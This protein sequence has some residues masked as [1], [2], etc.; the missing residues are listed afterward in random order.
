VRPTILLGTSEF[1]AK[2]RAELRT[3]GLPDSR[4]VGVPPGY[5][6]LAADAFTALVDGVVQR[7]RG[8]WGWRPQ[9]LS[10]HVWQH[11]CGHRGHHIIISCCRQ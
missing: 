7:R 1:A 6:R 4:F 8:Q 3:G 11:P 10:A 5:E 2:A 9:P